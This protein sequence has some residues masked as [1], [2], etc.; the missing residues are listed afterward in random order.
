MKITIEALPPGGEEEIIIRADRL[1]ERIM[2]LIQ[3]IKSPTADTGASRFAGGGDY[4]QPDMDGHMGGAGVHVGGPDADAGRYTG[5]DDMESGSG[6]HAGGADSVRH[7]GG[8]DSGRLTVFRE[9]GGICL[10]ETAEIYYFES[11]DDRVFAYVKDDVA[12]VKRKLY[13]L[14]E[15]LAGDDFIR[16]SKSMILNLSKVKRFAPYMG[17]RFEA[18][19][20]NGEKV[21]ISRQYVPELKKVL[22][23]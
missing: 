6:R 23:L 10:V 4:G 1:D 5:M 9:G 17:G 21:L 8:P 19:L 22:G 13:E 2:A 14:E 16:I 15:R 3:A 7:A 12:E 18:L 20:E 11:V